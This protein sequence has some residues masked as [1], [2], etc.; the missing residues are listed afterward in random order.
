MKQHSAPRSMSLVDR[1][2]H[3]ASSSLLVRSV[4]VGTLAIGVTVGGVVAGALV[5]A[6][7]VARASQPDATAQA[8]RMLTSVSSTVVATT[9]ALVAYSGDLA[10]SAIAS[11]P[12]PMTRFALAG[13]AL[14]AIVG[15][16]SM[17]FLRRRTTAR[18][19]APIGEATPTF[20][21]TAR[22]T[23]RAGHKHH[24]TPRAVHAL[25]ATGA[26]ATDIAWK[27]RLPIDAV[28]LLLAISTGTRQFQ[29]PAA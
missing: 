2:R 4:M 24:Q 8:T 12:E 9:R 29:P 18:S 10:S 14:V 23:P 27:T 15:A 28:Q 22:L 19:L 26:T 1:M 7:V 17:L 20:R 3:A 21:G 16:L 13:L 6:P 25:A 11:L 5:V